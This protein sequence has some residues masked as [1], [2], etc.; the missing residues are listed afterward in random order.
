MRHIIGF[1]GLEAE[2]AK[3]RVHTI[4]VRLD[5]RGEGI[6]V[7]VEGA[8]NQLV[9]GNRPVWEQASNVIDTARLTQ[10]RRRG[11]SSALRVLSQ[12]LPHPRR[13]LAWFRTPTRDVHGVK[14]FEHLRQAPEDRAAFLTVAHMAL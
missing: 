10:T 9:F 3:R 11:S 1:P 12:A 4:G 13:Q 8:R 7:A 5:E 14:L 6:L 2:P